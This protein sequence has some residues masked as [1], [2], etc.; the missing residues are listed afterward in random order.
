VKSNYVKIYLFLISYYIILWSI[1]F[2]IAAFSGEVPI[3]TQ[4]TGK[5]KM[6]TANPRDV[7]SL[8]GEDGEVGDGEG[9][10]KL[11]TVIQNIKK[12]FHHL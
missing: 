1:K 11:S 9:P 3:S 4:E 5:M 8:Q 12:S 6:R 7:P 2:A 10:I